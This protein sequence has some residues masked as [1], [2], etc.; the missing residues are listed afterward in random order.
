VN[1]RV[2]SAAEQPVVEPLAV[3]VIFGATVATVLTLVMVPTFTAP[4]SA[5]G[6]RPARL[7]RGGGGD[8]ARG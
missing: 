6:Q 1:L 8:A 5:A 4:S 3:A 7:R 2:C